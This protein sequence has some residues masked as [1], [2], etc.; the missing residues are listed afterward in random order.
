M[1]FSALEQIPVEYLYSFVPVVS[2]FVIWFIY[3]KYITSSIHKES[4]ESLFRNSTK[5][6]SNTDQVPWL[7][8]LSF[9]TIWQK[10]NQRQRL[11]FFVLLVAN[12]AIGII[13][14]IGIIMKLFTGWWSLSTLIKKPTHHTTRKE[15]QKIKEESLIYEETSS[16]NKKPH[17]PVTE[18]WS[19]D[20]NPPLFS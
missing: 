2:L 3:R 18:K 19:A 9:H 12:P 1:D 4:V 16:N 17:T 5:N 6:I 13:Y 14:G 11:L 7:Q 20:D 10:V 15:K 8:N